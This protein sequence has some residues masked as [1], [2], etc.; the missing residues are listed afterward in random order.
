MSDLNKLEIEVLLERQKF[1][2][3]LN[4][5][6]AAV[7]P[8]NVKAHAGAVAGAYGGDLGRQTW[9]AAKQNPAAFALVGAGLSLLLAGKGARSSQET[10]NGPD[11]ADA[12]FDERVAA[13]DAALKAD[14]TGLAEDDSAPQAASL[15]ARLHD[16]LDGL[17]DASREK[18][19]KARNAALAAQEK[20]EA[21]AREAAKSSKTFLQ[22]HPLAVGA[23]SLGLGALIGALLPTTRRE[24]AMMGEQ[25]DA[26]MASAQQIL[27]DEIE[28]VHREAMMRE[29]S[30]AG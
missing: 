23:V 2:E 13:A 17:S 16:G 21:Q 14:A 26:F 20:V 22:K 7:A 30:K 24:D 12:G 6:S 18:V 29:Q 3:A 4:T 15:R 11:Q 19:L 25:R 9:D 27:R 8:E 1:A 10:P 28:A 5:L